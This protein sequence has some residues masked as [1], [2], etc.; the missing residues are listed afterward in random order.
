MAKMAVGV[1][2]F[3]AAS[4]LQAAPVLV[5]GSSSF[6]G[7]I[8]GSW[9]HSFTTGSPDVSIQSIQI[10]LKPGLFFDTAAAAP[11]FLANQNVATSNLGGTGFTGFSASG[12]TLDGGNAVTLTFTNFTPGKTYTH[13]GDVDQALT[14]QNCN[15]LGGVALAACI[16]QNALITADASSVSG[17]EFAGS[18][19]VVIIGGVGYTPLVLTAAFGDQGFDSARADWS[20]TVV[21]EPS[22]W[23]LMTSGLAVAVLARRHWRPRSQDD[24]NQ[25]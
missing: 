3:A 14:L 16:A 17:A 5:S 2:L 13:V 4:W 12:A 10:I 21:P 7:G 22:T 11:G 15:G 18:Q 19:I 1:C 24:A 6:S 20:G 23:A 8:L 9:S 25:R